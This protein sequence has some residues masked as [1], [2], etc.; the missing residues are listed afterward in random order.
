M[1]DGVDGG[2]K[3]HSCSPTPGTLSSRDHWTAG[4]V[5]G[6]VDLTD[7]SGRSRLQGGTTDNDTSQRRQMILLRKTAD[8]RL[9]MSR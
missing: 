2:M 4:A 5:T 1:V 3:G 8:D 7:L 9:N 6:P